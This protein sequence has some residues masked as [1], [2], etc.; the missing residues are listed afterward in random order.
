[1]VLGLESPPNHSTT[2]ELL[3][4]KLGASLPAGWATMTPATQWG[5]GCHMGVYINWNTPIAGRFRMENPMEKWM[6]TRASPMD[7]KPPYVAIFLYPGSG[8]NGI[9]PMV[10]LKAC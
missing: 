3:I 1:M 4:E 9:V 8:S 6:M 7:W 10:I 2:Q 5:N